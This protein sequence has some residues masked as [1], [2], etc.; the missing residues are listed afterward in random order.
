MKISIKKIILSI[1]AVISVILCI[2]IITSYIFVH[3]FFNSHPFSKTQWTPEIQKFVES[4]LD[5]PLPDSV[6]V[7]YFFF[8]T[9]MDYHSELLISVPYSDVPKYIPQGIK[10][11][12]PFDSKTE[13]L[14]Y[15]NSKEIDY[16]L[17]IKLK[18]LEFY[19]KYSGTIPD[20]RVHCEVLVLSQQDFETLP[21]SAPVEVLIY[22]FEF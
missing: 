10:E 18:E 6:S 21:S 17:K 12:A 13:F 3:N 20:K 1:V 2:L 7:Q 22:F 15:I 19:K 4:E 9:F 14:G 11:D 5:V 8:E 16:S